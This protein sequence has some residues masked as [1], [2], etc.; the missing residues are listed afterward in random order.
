MTE[1]LVHRPKKTIIAAAN[2]P[3]LKVGDFLD[4]DERFFKLSRGEHSSDIIQFSG[5]NYVL[6][7]AALK[8]YREY[9]TIDGYKNDVLALVCMPF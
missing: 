8:C 1:Y 6:G 2:R 3:E 7:M 9:K 4:L 5:K